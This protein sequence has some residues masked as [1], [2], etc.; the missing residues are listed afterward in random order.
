MGGKNSKVGCKGY[1]AEK[2]VEEQLELVE[3]PIPQNKEIV[4]INMNTIVEKAMSAVL[5]N[6]ENKALNDIKK[7]MDVIE[8]INGVQLFINAYAKGYMKVC[9]YIIT[10]NKFDK[11]C[12]NDAVYVHKGDRYIAKSVIIIILFQQNM[13]LLR[14][15][16]VHCGKYPSDANVVASFLG[17]LKRGRY[18][19]AKFIIEKFDIKI[20]ESYT[21]CGHYIEFGDPHTIHSINQSGP[22]ETF[23]GG[24]YDDIIDFV[25][26][27]K[28]KNMV[29]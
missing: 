3:K 10:E 8:R 5:D 29:H 12:H 18:D 22:I 24:L 26:Y 9:N 21:S 15:Y 14:L 27:L 13:E 28:K 23:F 1:V 16:D 4:T 6:D 11:S 7:F 2:L 20:I 19:I 17:S 25:N